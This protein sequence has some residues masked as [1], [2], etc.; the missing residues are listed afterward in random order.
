MQKANEYVKNIDSLDFMS[1]LHKRFKQSV[2][3]T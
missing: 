2:E 3:M 1:F